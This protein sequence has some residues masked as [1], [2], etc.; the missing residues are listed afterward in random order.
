MY[1]SPSSRSRLLLVDGA[2]GAA[3]GSTARAY[4]IGCDVS[5]PFIQT[6]PLQSNSNSNS[7]GDKSGELG[8]ILQSAPHMLTGDSVAKDMVGWYWRW[9]GFGLDWID[10]VWIDLVWYVR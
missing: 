3:A 10:L 7:G 9:I 8:D 5:R 1:P 6:L 2:L 4:S